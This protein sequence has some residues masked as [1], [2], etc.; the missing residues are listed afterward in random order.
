MRLR[1]T[2][3]RITS[4]LATGNAIVESNYR[5]EDVLMIFC[6]QSDIFGNW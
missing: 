1:A 3:L 4:G 2:S 5:L 6:W